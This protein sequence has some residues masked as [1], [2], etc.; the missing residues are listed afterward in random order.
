MADEYDYSVHER[1]IECTVEGIVCLELT[2]LRV[3][4]DPCILLVGDPNRIDPN[5]WRPLTMSSCRFYGSGR[6]LWSPGSREYRRVNIEVLMSIAL[7]S[8]Q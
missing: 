7:G 6:N 1:S 2:I 5:L 3:H 4:A 8:S